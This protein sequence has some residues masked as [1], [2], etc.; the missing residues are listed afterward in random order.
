MYSDGLTIIPW[1]NDCPLVWDAT[2]QFGTHMRSAYIALSPSKAGLVV[3]R[4]KREIYTLSS[5][6][7]TIIISSIQSLLSLPVYLGR[8]P[9]HYSSKKL[10][11][12]PD[13]SL[14]ISCH[15][16]NFARQVLNSPLKLIVQLLQFLV[17]HAW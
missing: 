11:P 3:A 16:L 4:K 13:W 14:K 15:I 7:I 8:M 5:C 6:N 1:V 10:H 17:A 9:D 2:V 12:A